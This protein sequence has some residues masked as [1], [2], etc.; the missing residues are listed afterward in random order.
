MS[1]FLF[2]IGM[3]NDFINKD[4]AYP[5]PDAGS[6]T[7]HVLKEV[8]YFGNNVALINQSY[9][10]GHDRFDAS[11]KHCVEETNGVEICSSNL[12]DYKLF[13][14]NDILNPINEECVE[15]LKQNNV[16]TVCICG[17]ATEEA[18]WATAKKTVALG[19]KTYLIFDMCRGRDSDKI[20]K[21]IAD[22]KKIGVIPTPHGKLGEVINVEKTNA[23]R[24]RNN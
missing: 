2:I 15:L 5:V 10:E 3:Q 14:T 12:K 6:I 18:V 16:T 8:E 11:P 1:C 7:R 22:L 20:T 23:A 13:K 9:P 24:N 17:V 21:A 19:F 4:G